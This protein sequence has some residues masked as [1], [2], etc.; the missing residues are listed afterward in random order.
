MDA[1]ATDKSRLTS[2]HVTAGSARAP[3]R[4]YNY[5]MGFSDTEIHQPFVGVAT[6]WNETAPCNIS[7]TRHE[8]THMQSLL[9]ARA[10]TH[11]GGQAE[12]NTY[13]DI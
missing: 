4:S 5:A 2:R 9:Q 13:A 12:K 7:L 6:C 1:N 3:H 11:P 8:N 10:N